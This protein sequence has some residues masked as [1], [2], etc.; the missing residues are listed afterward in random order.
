MLFLGQD[1]CFTSNVFSTY[2]LVTSE[3]SE[4]TKVRITVQSNSQL[5]HVCIILVEHLKYHVVTQESSNYFKRK[6][7]G[8]LMSRTLHSP[9]FSEF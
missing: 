2:I 6:L 1:I 5:Y 8:N 7:H 3:V 4:E 9:G